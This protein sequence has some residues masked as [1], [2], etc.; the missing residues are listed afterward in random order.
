MRQDKII[1]HNHFQSISPRLKHQP[2]SR[3]TGQMRLQQRLWEFNSK[4][5]FTVLGLLKRPCP[6]YS[7][8]TPT[9]HTLHHQ[10]WVIV[11][12]IVTVATIVNAWAVLPIHSTT[13]RGS[14]FGKWVPWSVW[15]ERSRIWKRSMDTKIRSFPLNRAQVWRI[16]PSPALVIPWVMMSNKT[17]C[18]HTRSRQQTR[19]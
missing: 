16:T 2:I 13:P 5:L 17:Q 4:T 12:T 14:M 1:I 19:T 10:H 3:N 15:T 7:Q 9:L 18:N 6:H 11:P 8:A